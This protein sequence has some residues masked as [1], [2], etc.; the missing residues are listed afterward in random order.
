MHSRCYW[1]PRSRFASPWYWLLGLWA[2]EVSVW[3]LYGL[4]LL[5]VTLCGKRK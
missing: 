4:V 1:S 3:M 2:V 5:V